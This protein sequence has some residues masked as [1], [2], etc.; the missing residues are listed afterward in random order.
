M[1][2]TNSNNNNNSRLKL[3][4]KMFKALQKQTKNNFY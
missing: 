1:K 4:Y 2:E 3:K